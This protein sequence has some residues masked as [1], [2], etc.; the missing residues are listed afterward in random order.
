MKIICISAS[1]TKLIGT[2]STSTKVCEMIKEKI[3][4]EGNGAQAEVIPLMDY[5]LKNCFFC[6]DCRYNGLCVHDREFNR[7]QSKIADA[8]GVFIVLPHYS[9]IP[10]KLLMVFEKINEILY[11]GWI[12]DPEFQSSL[13][14]KPVALI[15]HGGM[16]EEEQTLRYYHDHLITPVSDTLKSLSYQIVKND[17]SYPNGAVFGLKDEGCLQTVEHEVFPR[18]IQDW[19]AIETRISSLIKNLLEKLNK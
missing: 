18:I 10:S 11:G 17:D 5:D 19:Q 16:A 4:K 15:G 12:N 1:N 3:E 8:D 13:N 14:N 7:L 2:N 9:P 6:G